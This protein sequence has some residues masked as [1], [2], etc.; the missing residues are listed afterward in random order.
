MRLRE[1]INERFGVGGAKARVLVE[2]LRHGLSVKRVPGWSA[3]RVFLGDIA[4]PYK[5]VA[6]ACGVDWR[7]VRETLRE[8]M[9]EPF[10]REFFEKLENAGPFLRGVTKLLGYRCIVVE[11]IHDQPGILAYV[12]GILAEKGI[13]ILQVIAEHPL[14]VDNPKLY[15]IIQG[16]VP[17]DFVP[18]V[19]QHSAIKSVTVY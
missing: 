2:L 8:V 13:N 11:T 14:L 10:L 16:E 1:E 4:I 7:T 17:G 18:R 3:P 12:S 19:L 5:S 15:I 6:Q 9:E